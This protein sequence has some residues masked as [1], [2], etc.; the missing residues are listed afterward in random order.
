VTELSA[1]WVL[2]VD[3]PPIEGGVVRFED[4]RLV[5]VGPGRA[6]R[7]FSDAA[8]VPGFVNAHS[9]LE[10]SVYAGF[11]DG[12]PFGPWIELHMERKGRLGADEMLAVARRGVADS[13]GSGI[14]TTADYAFSGAAAT[15]AAELG[16]RA[17]V[18]LEVFGGDAADAQARFDEKRAALAESPLVQIGV[19][20][21]APYSCSLEVYEWCLSLGIPVG[22][23]LAESA[24]EN[25]WLEHGAGPLSAIAPFLQPPTG[26]RAV[27]TLEPVL[28]PDLLCAHCVEIDDAEIALLAQRQVRVAHCPRS[29]ALLGCGIAPLA[30]L[31]AA[32]VVVGLGTDSPASAPS[33]DCFEEMRAAIYAA[34]GRERRAGALLASEA[35]EL[36]TVDAAR[37]LRMDAEV[38][39]LTP[40]KRAD[41]AVVSLAG[42]PYHPVEDP[43]AAVVFG[44]SPERVL[45]TIVDGQTRYTSEESNKWRE[46]RNIASAAR[47]RML[48]PRQ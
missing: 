46:V 7:H 25:E 30:D 36:A 2:P 9:H 45:E 27:A 44:G 4:G 19:S 12:M 6:D 29:N 23:H 40:G 24:N 33:F 20:P 11:G 21:H 1:D 8:I 43:A 48:A 39:T 38:G 13:L 37:A 3:G 22:T 28:G 10:Y 34:R 17:I 15:A 42:S 26:L 41:L 16:L 35:L 31:R 47:R 14:T 32:G 5:E 18:Y